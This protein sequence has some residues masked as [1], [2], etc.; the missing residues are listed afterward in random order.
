MRRSF[1]SGLQIE[2]DESHLQDYDSG[3]INEYDD[4]DYEEH[5]PHTDTSQ[6]SEPH[7]TTNALDD[8]R[9]RFFLL[10]SRNERQLVKESYGGECGTTYGEADN[11]W[12]RLYKSQTGW[13]GGFRDKDKWEVARWLLKSNTLQ[14]DTERFAKL[15][16]VSEKM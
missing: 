12:I 14:G 8:A 2:E 5:I 3:A 16:Y 1:H 13:W 15:C 6:N 7:E 4:M 10:Q 9:R 11:A